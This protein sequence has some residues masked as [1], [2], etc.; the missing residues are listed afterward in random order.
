MAI[1]LEADVSEA[2]W[3]EVPDYKGVKFKI[4]PLTPEYIKK[5]NAKYTIKKR[6]GGKTSEDTDKDGL[7]KEWDDNII[8]DWKGI[9]DKHSQPLPC[10]KE[11]KAIFF[12]K[13]LTFKTF[14]HNE[15][16]ILATEMSIIEVA[17]E[18]N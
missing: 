9:V 5:I 2:V 13:F 17:E 4:K 10:N 12:K 6:V 1:N 8:E 3:K 11:T 7:D 14:I 15:A 16:T 18:K